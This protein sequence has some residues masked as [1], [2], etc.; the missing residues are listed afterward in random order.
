MADTGVREPS[1][2]G[3]GRP[4]PP[5]GAG[6]QAAVLAV[7]CVVFVS[8]AVSSLRQKSAVWDE[9][10][11]LTAGYAALRA[12]R[13]DVEPTNPPLLRAWSAL[14]LLAMPG[15]GLRLDGPGRGGMGAPALSR[16]FLYRDNDADA[17]LYPAR[18][19]TVILGVL[20]GALL[21]H[22]ALELFGFVPATAVLAL[23]TF[24]PGVL[25]HSRLVTTDVGASLLFFAACYF[26]WR[27]CRRLSPAALLGLAASTGLGIAGKWTLLVLLPVTAALLALRALRPEPWPVAGRDGPVATRT[28]RSLL[29]GLLLAALLAATALSLW[30]AYGFRGRHP[31]PRGVAA[32]SRL[33]EVRSQAP[34]MAAAVDVL[35]RHR[36]LPS[37]ALQGFLA[38]WVMD[39]HRPSFLLGTVRTEGRWYFAPLVFLMKT[40]LTTLAAGLA[41]VLLLLWRGR[42]GTGHGR[43]LPWLLLPPGA[44]MAAAAASGM[45]VGARHLLPALPFLLLAAG[46]VFATVRHGR[47]LAAAAVALMLL[48]CAPAYPD[49]LAFVN[50]AAT[51]RK[52]GHRLLADSNLDWGQDLKGVGRWMR[53]HGVRHVNLGYFGQADP[54]FYGIGFTPLPGPT[55]WGRPGPPR[56][57]GWVAVSATRLSGLYLDRA[58]R[59]FYRPLRQRRPDEAIGGSILLYFVERPWW[60]PAGDSADD[61]PVPGPPPAPTR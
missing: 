3:A 40:P 41:G 38:G 46:A 33:P 8:L 36:L 14:P 13:F 47:R 16:T 53:E 37:E 56:L 7:F 28:G 18:G 15:I 51:A 9:P 19:M 32:A 55:P 30:A 43:D 59:D 39:A 1:P 49:Y 61:D 17:L 6:R 23:Y 57:P 24:S 48:E 31:S 4:A 2:A 44:L 60:T 21:F 58:G 25:A 22:W 34:R 20:L 52:P 50:R 10:Q 45:A 26:L 35:D 12:G 54:S 27:C 42:G 5:A 29:A 11:H